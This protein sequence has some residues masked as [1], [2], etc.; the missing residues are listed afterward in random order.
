[1]TDNRK[2]EFLIGID[3]SRAFVKDPAG[4]EYYSLNLIKNI[5]KIDPP[6]GGQVRY[7]LYLRPGQKPNFQ[8]PQNFE[9]K[10]INLRYLWTQL[11]LAFETIFNPS[12]ILFIPAHT[13][14]LLTRILRPT[15]KIVV[16]IHGLEGKFLPQ[17]SKFFVHFYR[18]WSIFLA[19][20]FADKLIAVSRDTKQDIIKTYR[21]A[22]KKIKVIHE[23]IDIK[24]FKNSQRVSKYTNYILFVGTVQPRKNLVRLIEAFS[25]L[26]DKKINLLIA[27]KLGWLYNDILAA[28]RRFGVEDRV[29]FFG[30][31]SDS[32][33]VSLY[34]GARLFV[35]PSITEGFG[36]PILEAQAAGIPVVC[37]ERGALPEVAGNGVF[38]VNPLSVDNIKRGLKKILKDKGLREEL[39]R[40]SFENVKKFSWEKTAH[41][42]LNFLLKVARESKFSH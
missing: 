33:L 36:L 19:V 2:T 28:P 42:T 32:D 41:N 25:K 10:T 24:R 18:N 6:V 11:G 15:T 31:V 12:D 9:S 27:G 34:K 26:Q 3:A 1:M 22:S 16:T 13:L 29:V 20:R 40:K 23:G 30:R 5:T 38:F 17:S 39:V 8:L 21:I 35:L 7:R 4:P 14:P 37:S